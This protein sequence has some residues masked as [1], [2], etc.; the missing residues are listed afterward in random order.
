MVMPSLIHCTFLIDAYKFTHDKFYLTIF[1]LA[2]QKFEELIQGSTLDFFPERLD[3]GNFVP[4][5]DLKCDDKPQPTV[6]C[7]Q[8]VFLDIIVS[9]YLATVSA[10]QPV[11]SFLLK[12]E[13]LADK[14]M[15]YRSQGIRFYDLNDG[16]IN[17]SCIRGTLAR[18]T[19]RKISLH[20]SEE[21]LIINILQGNSLIIEL[22]VPTIVGNCIYG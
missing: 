11:Q 14:I 3:S 15:N 9:A 19:L 10:G 8:G 12:A 6:E 2:W 7:D 1:E 18:N 16:L 17:E 5:P 22:S 20:F 4:Q 21:N 13:S